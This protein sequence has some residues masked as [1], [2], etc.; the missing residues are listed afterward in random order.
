M[1]TMMYRNR[2]EQLDAEMYE[3]QHGMY[4]A[5]LRGEGTLTAEECVRAHL[6]L[7]EF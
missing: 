2:T 1:H 3:Q 6:R 5:F 4:L 7:Y